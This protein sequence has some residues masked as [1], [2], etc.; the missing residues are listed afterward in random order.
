MQAS[1]PVYRQPDVLSDTPTAAVLRDPAQPKLGW[2]IG[3]SILSSLIALLFFPPILG[4]IG[5][6]L[7]GYIFAKGQ[8]TTGLALIVAGVAAAIIGMLLAAI[9]LS[10]TG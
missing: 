6:I 7:G 1:A 8:K 2:Q 5:A 4:A 10:S 3:A 9:A